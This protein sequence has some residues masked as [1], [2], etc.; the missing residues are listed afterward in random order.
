MARPKQVTLSEVMNLK[1]VLW[2]IVE[3]EQVELE[4]SLD[5]VGS[6]DNLTFDAVVLEAANQVGQQTPPDDI[7]SGGSTDTLVV[8]VP[9]FRGDWNANISYALDET[10]AYGEAHYR[11]MDSGYDHAVAPDMNSSWLTVSPRAV[12]IRIPSTYSA[13]YVVQPTVSAP[14]YGFFELSVTE[15]VGLF[16][17][18]WKPIRGMIQI[19]FSPRSV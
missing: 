6:L 12:Y 1:D 13:N 19:N 7:R 9:V 3:G 17:R 15:T 2:R 14:T 18:T 5:F 8:R 11:L 16:P 10:V 4:V